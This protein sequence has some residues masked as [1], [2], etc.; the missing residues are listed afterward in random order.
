MF[1]PSS[2]IVVDITGQP[3]AAR[4]I[5]IDTV[6]S[7]FA[8]AGAFLVAALVVALLGGGTFLI[9][10]RMHAAALDG[11][12]SGL[13][14]LDLSTPEDSTTTPEGPDQGSPRVR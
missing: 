4:D 1:Q 12:D 5:S 11:G 13:T 6:L 7:I 9:Y 8:L 2:P 10:R 3:E 14:T